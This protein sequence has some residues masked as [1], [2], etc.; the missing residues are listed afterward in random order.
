[1]TSLP[2]SSAERSAAAGGI[3]Y[4]VSALMF[5]DLPLAAAL[6]SAELFGSEVIAAFD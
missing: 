2:N 4:F 5:G 6:R 1:M 3:N